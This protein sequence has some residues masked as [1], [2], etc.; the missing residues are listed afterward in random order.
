MTLNNLMPQSLTQ[1][2]PQTSQRGTPRK[3]SSMSNHSYDQDAPSLI[4]S[5]YESPASP[6]LIFSDHSMR[7]VKIPTMTIMT[8][9]KSYD[10]IN[11]NAQNNQRK[12]AENKSV[13]QTFAKNKRR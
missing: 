10:H 12:Q 4:L 1:T 5:D 8:S 9:A 11:T 7:K 3:L 2:T 6:P 13:S